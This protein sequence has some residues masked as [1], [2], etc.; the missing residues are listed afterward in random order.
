MKWLRLS[1]RTPLHVALAVSTDYDI[2]RSL[3][4]N[5][6]D[7]GNR[8][9]EGKT[10]C[11]TF[12]NATVG[13]VLL[14]HKEDMEDLQACDSNG[15]G[16][17]HYAAWS[18]K[19]DFGHVLAC[20]Q[21]DDMHA[22]LARDH[23]G[24]RIIHL[25]AQRGN[26][27]VLHSLMDLHFDIDINCKDIAGQTALHYA[28]ESKRVEAIK[29]LI[30]KGADIHAVDS[31]GRTPM[32]R[33]AARNN[34]L[35]I[36]YIVKLSG[37]GS[38]HKTDYQGKTPEQLARQYRAILAAE[39]L[40][41]IGGEVLCSEPLSQHVSQANASLKVESAQRLKSGLDFAFSVAA[42]KLEVILLYLMYSIAV[43]NASLWLLS[44]VVV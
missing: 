32:H 1:C 42:C 25:A 24:R 12:F 16:I 39:H 44:R 20:I 7:L 34:L 21:P 18:S 26:I 43:W 33:A 38:I 37:K 6:A 3:I 15:M 31:N 2:P 28:A 13:K 11:H 5:G 14:L 10:P 41:D 30:S 35:A 36:D 22:F 23:L 8:D 40:R 19:S 9:V 17:P 27:E 4:A 29:L